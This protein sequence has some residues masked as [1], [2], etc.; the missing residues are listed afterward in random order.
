MMIGDYYHALAGEGVLWLAICFKMRY[1]VSF[2][3][4]NIYRCMKFVRDWYI[5]I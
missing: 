1:T 4:R 2:E 5:F 3:M